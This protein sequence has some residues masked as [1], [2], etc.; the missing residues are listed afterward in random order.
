MKILC[1]LLGHR[2]AMRQVEHA[3]GAALWWAECP[4]CRKRLS[5]QVVVVP[6]KV[7]AACGGRGYFIS[8]G[9]SKFAC[10]SCGATGLIDTL[11]E[12]YRPS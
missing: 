5:E 7:C 4:R 6:P 9:G 3:D 11:E 12:D 1:K 2:S 8:I 10:K